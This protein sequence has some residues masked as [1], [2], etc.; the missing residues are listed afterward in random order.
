MKTYLIIFLLFGII[1]FSDEIKIT[2]KK[3]KSNKKEKT[4]TI[5]S[6]SNKLKTKSNVS[7]DFGLWL[8]HQ[9]K[10]YKNSLTVDNDKAEE[11]FKEL[12][13]N[14]EE[15]DK[16]EKVIEK[17]SKDADEGTTEEIIRKAIQELDHQRGKKILK[18]MVGKENNK[19]LSE[20]LLDTLANSDSDKANEL[21]AFVLEDASEE[22]VKSIQNKMLE[23][24]CD[25]T[26]KTKEEL[27]SDVRNIFLISQEF[28]ETV[29]LFRKE[30]G[31]PLVKY[32]KDMEED[33]LSKIKDLAD[34][35]N[36]EV[37]K[38]P[39]KN[40]DETCGTYVNIFINYL[41]VSYH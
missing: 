40:G 12:K 1:S 5:T 21:F 28:L 2:H 34:N 19:K 3:K 26:G 4:K 33:G 23:V 36:Q 18:E 14:F 29:N 35:N 30:K 22:D 13:E 24:C 37:R 16:V 15:K 7:Q 8:S 39:I 9:I 10:K 31:L 20:I 6:T 41:I 38:S 32:N 27:W 25:K 11:L 17:I